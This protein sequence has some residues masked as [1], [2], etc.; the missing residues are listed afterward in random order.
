[1]VSKKDKIKKIVKKLKGKRVPKK[2]KPTQKQKQKQSVVQ[3][4]RISQAPNQRAIGF[5]TQ[6]IQQPS[7]DTE[8]LRSVIQQQNQNNLTRM[9][10]AKNPQNYVKLDDQLGLSSQ[11]AFPQPPPPSIEATIPEEQ[12]PTTTAIEVNPQ[13]VAVTARLL[14]ER[15]PQGFWKNMS[16]A[17]LAQRVLKSDEKYKDEKAAAQREINRR[18]NLEAT[19]SRP[20]LPKEEQNPYLT[21]IYKTMRGIDVINNDEK[22][23]MK[24]EGYVSD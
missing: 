17:E 5:P 12:T 15:K 2:K 23:N 11:R 9:Y 20:I 24:R 14:K 1:M 4:V 7:S 6:V 8:F 3:N 21:Q 18:K 10:E 19:S 16:S 13:Q 22:Q